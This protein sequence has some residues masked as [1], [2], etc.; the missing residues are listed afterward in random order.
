MVH[1]TLL[2]LYSLI[3]DPNVVT[4]HLALPLYSSFLCHLWEHF[5][6]S[7]LLY[8]YL[9]CISLNSQLLF[10]LSLC[11]IIQYWNNLSSLLLVHHIWVVHPSYGIWHHSILWFLLFIVGCLW[12][13]QMSINFL[14][15]MYR[16]NFFMTSSHVWKE[17][18]ILHQIPS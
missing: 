13:M 12:H 16:N 3:I 7:I 8:A 14:V 11:S 17:W 4:I 5:L 10:V 6:P 18:F 1:F 15:G 2:P 9:A